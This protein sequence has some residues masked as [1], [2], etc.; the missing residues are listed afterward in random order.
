MPAFL[1]WW[2]WLW[3]W[4]WWV[5]LL[6]AHP[7]CWSMDNGPHHLHA[8]IT[9]VMQVHS[10]RALV[11]TQGPYLPTAAASVARHNGAHWWYCGPRFVGAGGAGRWCWQSSSLVCMCGGPRVQLWVGRTWVLSSVQHAVSNR[12]AAPRGPSRWVALPSSCSGD[13]FLPWL[14]SSL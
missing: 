13:F 14:V 2:R 9:T 11:G 8:I 5:L 12:L 10:G 3:R 6:V 7:K 1:S 4:W